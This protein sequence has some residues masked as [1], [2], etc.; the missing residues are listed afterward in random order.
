L[1]ISEQRQVTSD[2]LQTLSINKHIDE[3][4][5]GVDGFTTFMILPTYD[6]IIYLGRIKIRYSSTRAHSETFYIVAI[7]SHRKIDEMLSE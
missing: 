4:Q 3:M 5:R 2:A 1:E 7:L 6:P